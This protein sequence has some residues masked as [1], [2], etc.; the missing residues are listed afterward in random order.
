MEFK[1]Q[2]SIVV[3]FALQSPLVRGDHVAFQ[4][5]FE[6]SR[7]PFAEAAKASEQLVATNHLVR[8]SNVKHLKQVLPK[9]EKLESKMCGLRDIQYVYRDRWQTT[10]TIERRRHTG[11]EV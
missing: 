1:A 4:P 8:I 10:E 11:A 3:S 6:G 2:V 7:H 5:I 9:C